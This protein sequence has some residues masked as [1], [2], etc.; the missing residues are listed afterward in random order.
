MPAAAVTIIAI[1]LVFLAVAVTGLGSLASRSRSQRQLSAERQRRQAIEA[2]LGQL[3]DS[4]GQLEAQLGDLEK[5]LDASRRGLGEEAAGRWCLELARLERDWRVLAGPGAR[6]GVGEGSSSSGDA[7]GKALEVV[8]ARL[9]EEVGTPATVTVASE[10][11]DGTAV[12][13]Q[14]VVCVLRLAEEAMESLAG[15]C[16]WMEVEVAVTGAAGDDQPGAQ[17]EL[18]VDIAAHEAG[19]AAPGSLGVVTGAAPMLG[20]A[21]ALA[22]DEGDPLE[23]HEVAGAQ[24][25]EASMAGRSGVGTLRVGLSCPN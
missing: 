22:W 5:K 7:L 12:R 24:G 14:A 3:Q 9:R 19:D 10:P 1:A 2:S 18:R 17:P 11:G 23:P 15:H 16:A 6:R 8:C 25:A 4:A 21:V 20:C 13:A